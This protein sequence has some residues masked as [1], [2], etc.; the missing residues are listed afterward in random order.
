MTSDVFDYVIVGGGS[1]GCILA[2]RLSENPKH[3]VLLLEAG[4]DRRPLYV[5]MPAAFAFASRDGSFS[6]EY[7]TEPE[8]GLDGRRIPCPRGRII[9]GSSAI[10]AM[11][12]VRG[13]RDDF[14]LWAESAGADWSY[15]ACLPYFR[16]I[17]TFTGSPSEW[18]G[19]EG[20]TTVRAPDYSSP[21]YAPFLAACREAGYPVS[22][23]TN[24]RDQEGFGPMDQNIRGGYRCSSADAFLT[25]VRSRPNL[26]IRDHALVEGLIMEGTIAAGVRYSRKGIPASVRARAEVILCAGAIGSPQI[27]MLSGIGEAGALRGLGIRPLVDLPAVGRHMA[28]HVDVS[29]KQTITKPVSSTPLMYGLRKIGVGLRWLLRHDGPGATNH[30]EVAGYIRTRPQESQPD[31]QLCFAP[32]L[33]AYDGTRFDDPHGYMLSIMLLRPESEGRLTLAS[34]DPRAAPRLLFNY[35]TAGEDLARL[36]DGLRAARRIFASPALAGLS[37]REILPGA[38]CDSDEE[39]AAF[40]RATAKSTHH[41][42]GTC[43]MS[44][45]PAEG[46]VDPEGRVRGTRGL[47]VIDA[48]IMPSITSGNINAPTL[49]LAAKLA[50]RVAAG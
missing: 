22:P 43:R 35:L 24:G 1:A 49:M 5:K 6:W 39:I 32:L 12:F 2:N 4:A 26:E 25:P 37:G 13:H 3:R 45:D 21:L 14:D 27:L 47:R 33:A 31:V 29:I 8:P 16:Q 41:P 50:D 7:A 19:T 36:R 44:A 18:R 28:D 17:E 30:F 48:S 38:G 11:A 15:D 46:V 23:D 40:I 42:C 9:G 34:P 20:P 10:N